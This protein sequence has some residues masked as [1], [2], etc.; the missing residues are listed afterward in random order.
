M[1]KEWGNFI[2]IK[3]IMISVLQNKNNHWDQEKV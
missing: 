2:C 3:I 1:E